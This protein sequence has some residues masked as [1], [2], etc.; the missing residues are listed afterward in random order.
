[1]AGRRPRDRAPPGS[2]PVQHL[3]RVA[4]LERGVGEGVPVLSDDLNRDK[5]PGMNVLFATSN[6]HKVIE[7]RG[8]LV[9][10]GVKVLSIAE[11][12]AEHDVPLPIEPE[13]SGATFEENA[14][15]KAIYYALALGQSCLAED[16]G[17]VVDAL[18]GAP[19]VH[20]A[21]YSGSTGDRQTKDNANNALL[22]SN[23]VGIP[24]S[25]RTARF[26][27]AASFSAASGVIRCRARGT[28]E[29]RIL[30]EPRGTGSKR[31]R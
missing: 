17:L 15:L 4:R 2:V 13:E 19:G 27:C 3:A 11:W 23:L 29:G 16:S 30:K 12:C 18:D 24:D 20:S 8:I 21:R 28:L 9:H 1:V 22:L 6:P 5:A 14:D 26:V 7:A 25:S 10:L 31:T